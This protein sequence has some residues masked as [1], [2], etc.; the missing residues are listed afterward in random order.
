[1][2]IRSVEAELFHAEA[3]MTQLKESLQAMLRTWLKKE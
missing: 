2:N 3:D 1:M